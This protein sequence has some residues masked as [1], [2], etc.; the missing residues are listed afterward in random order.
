LTGM[1]GKETTIA[2]L[3]AAQATTANAEG[4][5][6][7][8][9][10]LATL[11][12]QS[13]KAGP[14]EDMLSLAV[15][16]DNKAMQLALVRG[17]DRGGRDPKAKPTKGTAPSKVAKLLW[18]PAEPVAMAKL[19]AALTDKAGA[20]ALAGVNERV[21]WAGKPGAPKPPVVTPLTVAQAASFERGK[22]IFNGLCAA[23]HQPHGYGLDGLAPPLVDS[24]WVLGKPD[25]V[26]RII[27]NGL[28]GPV[29]VGG[30]TW[31]LSMPP[32]AQLNDED[33][34]A[35]VTYVRREWEH[36]AAPVD[37]K[38]VKTLRDQFG[39]HASWSADELRPPAPAKK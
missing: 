28:G 2:K 4:A 29:K 12:S 36:T 30:R 38:L 8:V 22:T 6:F 31:D 15:T 37:A 11:V 25:V 10:A 3:V 33:L 14:V 19:T 17:L 34:A 24:E 32:M 20:A 5:G 1:R 7:V 23:C 18:L 13:G 21:M 27:M 9:E 35:V 16:L 39:T 26:A